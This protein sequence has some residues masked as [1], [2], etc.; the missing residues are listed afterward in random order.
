MPNPPR[1][2]RGTLNAR[3]DESLGDL[4]NQ[5]LRGAIILAIGLWLAKWQI[6]D[7][8]HA[9][10]LGLEEVTIYKAA[11]AGAVALPP[12]G[13]F[14]IAFGEK[15]KEFFAAMGDMDSSNLTR[16]NVVSLLV[17]LAIMLV[18]GSLITQQLAAQGYFRLM[19]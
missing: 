9:A 12:L 17:F 7:P 11:L 5:R 15:A 14:F 3:G 6:W 4:M 8:L 2:T 18:I 13:L 1:R 10:E 19:H 16:G